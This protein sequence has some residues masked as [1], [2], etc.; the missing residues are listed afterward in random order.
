VLYLLATGNTVR[1]GN[2][3]LVPSQLPPPFTFSAVLMPDIFFGV[4]PPLT[5]GK[6]Q[7]MMYM[8]ILT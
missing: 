6:H 5:T 2:L 4:Q 8:Q 1:P 7:F 3:A